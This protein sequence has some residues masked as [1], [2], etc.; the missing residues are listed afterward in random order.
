M[1]K[2]KPV[3]LYF[4]IVLLAAVVLSCGLTFITFPYHKETTSYQEK[5][6]REEAAIKKVE[7]AVVRGLQNMDAKEIRECFSS[8]V[9]STCDDLDQGIEYLLRNF[10]NAEIKIIDDSYS[11]F[12]GNSVVILDVTCSLRIKDDTYNLAW[13]QYYES[14]KD[15]NLLGVYSMSISFGYSKATP[16]EI[17]GIYTPR[18]DDVTGV[19]LA[20][21]D[22]SRKRGT[23][24]AEDSVYV[25]ST[26]AYIFDPDFLDSLNE[27]EKRDMFGFFINQTIDY[28]NQIRLST[29][30]DG[31]I[32]QVEF[33]DMNLHGTL[34]L[35]IN[36]ENLINAVNF[37][38]S[39]EV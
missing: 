21:R 6:A 37:K 13:I 4:G 24:P 23:V 17:A 27:K 12:S 36:N 7:S 33:N 8:K 39:V 19:L 15:P 30:P 29:I 14:A 34:S 22:I 31:S 28:H 16:I 5:R 11:T 20:I 10:G 1:K 18:R 35:R 2:E 3:I 32:V 9:Q 26:W 38:P 25:E